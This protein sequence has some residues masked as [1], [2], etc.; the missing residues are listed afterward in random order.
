MTT[1]QTIGPRIVPADVYDTLVRSE[2]L[3]ATEIAIE[4]GVPDAAVRAAVRLAAGCIARDEFGRYAT[5]C[6]W[7]RVG[8]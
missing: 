1:L 8:M 6:A 7:P 3:T 2:P 5:W 4:L